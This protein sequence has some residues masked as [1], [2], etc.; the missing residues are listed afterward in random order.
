M[1][2]YQII[3]CRG[4]VAYEIVLS[5]QLSNLHNVFHV[6]QLR[7][8]IPDPSHVLESD[9]VQ[10]RENLTYETSPIR[11][12]DFK[13]K[14]LRGKSIR[15]VKIMWDAVTGDA[16]WELEDKMRELYPQIF[17]GKPIF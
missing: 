12:A 7:K 4:P 10:V 3:Q 11:V 6:S 2:P 1:G 9:D 15:L 8:Y 14:E 13:I 5:P 16:T 17:H